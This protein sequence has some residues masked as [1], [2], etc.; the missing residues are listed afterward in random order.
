MKST[1]LSIE[2]VPIGSNPEN[3]VSPVDLMPYTIAD[4]MDDMDT[5]T[6]VGMSRSTFQINNIVDQMDKLLDQ[7]CELEKKVVKDKV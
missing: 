6:I 5:T 4:L 3:I 1:L 7:F 2:E